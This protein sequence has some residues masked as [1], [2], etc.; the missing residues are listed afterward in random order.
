MKANLPT[1]EP[2]ALARW[3]AMGLYAQIRERAPGAPQVRPARRSAVRQRRRSTS[4]PRSTRSSRTSSS[5]RGRW[6]ASTRPTCPGYDCHGLPIELK[7]DRELGPK[8]REMSVADFRRACRAYAERFID[9]MTEEFKRLGILGDW[10]ASLPDDEL[11]LPGGDRA[12]A[13]QVR[14]AGARLQGQEAGPLVHPLPHR[15]GR[16]R[17][18][19]RGPHL[20][21]DL[22]RVPAVARQRRRAR[23]RASRRSRDATSRSSSGRRRPGRSRRTWRSRSTRSSTTRAYEVDGRAIIVAEALA[24]KVARGRRHDASARRS[25]GSR[26]SCSSGIRFRH[27]LYDRGLARRARRLRHARSRHRRRAHGAR[28]RRGRLHHR[29]PLR[30]RHLRAGRPGRPLPRRRCELFAGQ[31]VFDANPNVEEALNERARLWHRA[32]VHAPVPALLALPQPG[33][34]PGH[35]AV[36]HPHGRRAGSRSAAATKTLRAGRR[37][38]RST[39]TCTLDPGLGPRPHVQHAG[40]PARLVHLAPARLGRADPGGRLHDLRRG[41][42]DAGEL[43][44]RAASVFDEYGADAWYE[45]PIEEFLPAGLACPSCGGTAFE[46]ERDIL[47]VWFDSGSSHEAVL[48]FRP[49]LTWPA[50]IY[51][52]G[53]DQH[54]GW[55]QSSLLVGLGTRG[56]RRSA[57]V[58]THGFVV[59]VDGRKMSKSLGNIDR[60]RRT[61]IKESGA[62]ILRL[63]VAMVDYRE[64]VRVGKEILARV[65]EAY[66]KLRNTLRYLVVE[67]LRLRSGDRSRAAR[68]RCRRSIATCWRATRDRRGACCAATTR[69]DFPAIFQTLNQF[70]DGGPERVL[71]GRLEG[72]ALHVRARGSPERRSAQTA[73]YVDGRRPGAAARAD[74]AG[75]GRR[76]VAP[77]ARARA[78]TSVHLA[79][80]PRGRRARWSTTDLDARWTRLLAIR[81]AVN[82]ALE[83]A[84]QEKLIGTSLA[85]QVTLTAGGDD[86]GAAP[87][88]T[89]PSCRCC[90]SSRR[91]TLDAQPAATALDRRRWRART[92]RSASAAGATCP[93][94]RATPARDGP[95]R[96]LRRRA[97][98]RRRTSGRVTPMPIADGR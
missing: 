85:A 41:A 21:V 98:R 39:R 50:D 10:D 79:E 4:A 3:E 80:F 66:R 78:K 73:M 82:G 40:E 92:A 69:Y 51:L 29:R 64:E 52:E 67:P 7:V 87:R 35:V 42:A 13:G 18:R 55:F 88:A 6:P 96:P 31:Q 81:D 16:S 44:E 53:S 9:V 23:A 94:S 8:K 60:C 95:V 86:R 61:V 56:G 65:V 5:S 37:S 74:P 15:A 26:A 27:P 46:R 57:Q 34:L 20:A 12:R 43:V 22:R 63:W 47:D 93:T 84:R 48:P 62:E 90:S 91:S 77:P 30:P 32:D 89:R 11:Q 68:A 14:R 76:A 70:A 2:E 97:R 83:T 28:P 19:V 71:R 36:V 17:G 1:T 45:R 24:P 72:S 49:D 75:D 59:D 58:L 25:R 33:D 54:R 38:R